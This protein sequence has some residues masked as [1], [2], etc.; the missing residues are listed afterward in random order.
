MSA[1]LQLALVAV[2]ACVPALVTAYFTY[3]SS[4]EDADAGYQATREAVKGLQDAVRELKEGSA[5]KDLALAKMQGA[6]ETMEH[7]V[8]RAPGSAGLAG[9]QPPRGDRP[10]FRSPVFQL[11]QMPETLDQ[12]RTKNPNPLP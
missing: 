3:R 9:V 6:L 7:L 10:E 1:L 11:K 5:A 2:P 4:K 12:A 8:S